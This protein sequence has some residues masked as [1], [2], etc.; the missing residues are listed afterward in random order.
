MQAAFHRRVPK[1]KSVQSPVGLDM[2]QMGQFWLKSDTVLAKMF[3]NRVG[4]PRL[5]LFTGSL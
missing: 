5:T 4:G 2:L 1:I 3:R